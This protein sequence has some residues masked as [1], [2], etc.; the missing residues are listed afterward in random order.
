MSDQD[1]SWPSEPP[2]GEQP[3]SG[4]QP[5]ASPPPAQQPAY[6]SGG[7]AGGGDIEPRSGLPYAGYGQ[8]VGAYLIDIAVIVA[9]MIVVVV[10]GFVLGAISDVLGA[11][12]TFL[13]YLVAIAASIANL[14]MGEGGPLQQSLGKHMVGIKVV[15]PQPGPLG[16]GKA[17]IRWVGRILDTIVCGLPIGLVW[18]F[19][20]DQN[21]TWHDLVADTRVVVAQGGEKSPQYWLANF[22]G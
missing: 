17:A 9:L 2:S 3:P 1:P 20:D 12:F 15:G 14:I 11:I 22:R 7:G 19:F 8:R 18:P 6:G 16:Y 5:P 13:G 4:G 10:I 21:R